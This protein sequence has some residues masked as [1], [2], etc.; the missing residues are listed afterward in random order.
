MEPIRILHVAGSMHEA[1]LE[2][3]LM[4]VYRTIDRKKIQF[5][6]IVHSKKTYFYENEIRDLGGHVYHLSVR[7]DWNFLKYISDIMHI[8]KNH[9]E[10][11]IIEGHKETFGVMYFKVAKQCGVPIRIAHSHIASYPHNLH[12]YI[13]RFFSK[14]F[15]KYANDYV[16]VSDKAAKFLF[17]NKEYYLAPNGIIVDNFRFNEE[18]RSKVRNDMGLSDKFVIGH[19]GRF[20]KQKNHTFLIDIFY[21]YYK[22]HRNSV[23]MLIGTGELES[24]IKQKIRDLGIEDAVLFMGV[25]HDV[26][27]LL[28][29]MDLFLFPSLFEGLPGTLVEAQASGLNILCSDTITSEAR[30]TPCYKSFSLNNSADLWSNEIE[31]FNKHNRSEMG[32]YVK[33]SGYDA[34]DVAKNLEKRYLKLYYSVSGEE[35]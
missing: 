29:A 5:D 9:P 31:K 34:V 8:L 28:Q 18:I 3:W 23:L 6:F 27:D 13:G 11:K 32:D 4:N 30:M 7:D 21:S 12:G 35:Q 16:A 33:N 14:Q 24:D 20:Q 25:R 17:G 1:G 26:T 15:I 22:T 10:Y 2:T 19:V